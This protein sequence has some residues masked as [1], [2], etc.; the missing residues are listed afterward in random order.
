[1]INRYFFFN[2]LSNIQIFSEF[3]LINYML[4]WWLSMQMQKFYRAFITHSSWLLIADLIS[5]TK[6]YVMCAD[7]HRLRHYKTFRPLTY[8]S[9]NNNYFYEF[10]RKNNYITIVH[11]KN[12]IKGWK[13]NVIKWVYLDLP[14]LLLT[15][16]ITIWKWYKIRLMTSILWIFL[17]SF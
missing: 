3:L 14:Q 8:I 6:K 5:A 16:T 2:I 9:I 1:M 4:L 13:Y 11:I 15:F 12:D 7:F 10:S 17:E